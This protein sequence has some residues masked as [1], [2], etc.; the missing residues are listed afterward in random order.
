MTF[1]EALKI[2]KIEDYGERIFNSNSKGELFHLYV[3][4]QYAQMTKE[5]RQEDATMFRKLFVSAVEKAE[6]T[7]ERPE[8]VFQH[9]HT[10]ISEELNQNEDESNKKYLER[11]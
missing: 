8:S 2:L 6:K 7:W 1:K 5:A 10:V 9:L 11:D 3:Y 4:V